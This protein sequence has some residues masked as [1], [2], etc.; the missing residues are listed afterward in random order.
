M[1]ALYKGHVIQ[2]VKLAT[3]KYELLIDGR[4]Q[5]DDVGWTPRPTMKFRDT[6][7][8]RQQAI[9]MIDAE[10]ERKATFYSVDRERK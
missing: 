9:R 6:V 8:A 7:S 1:N 5:F 4:I 3:G 2:S 10:V